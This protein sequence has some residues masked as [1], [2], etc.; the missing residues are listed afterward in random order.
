[1]GEREDK[2]RWL[3]NWVTRKETEDAG[4]GGRGQE[5]KAKGNMGQQLEQTA[6]SILL[7]I[8]KVDYI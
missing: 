6:Y 2:G 8:Q 7:S 5:H 4:R 1:M 3:H